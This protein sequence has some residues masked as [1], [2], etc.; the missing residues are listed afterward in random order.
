MQH[1]V[2]AMQNGVMRPTPVTQSEISSVHG[3]VGAQWASARAA[4]AVFK[5]ETSAWPAIEVLRKCLCNHSQS[6]CMS[7]ARVTLHLSQRALLPQFA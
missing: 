7:S 3:H 1:A 4:E 5:P 6:G 2:Q